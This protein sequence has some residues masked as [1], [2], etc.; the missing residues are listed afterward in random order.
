MSLYSV[1]LSKL[2][3]G[4]ILREYSFFVGF[5]IIFIEKPKVPSPIFT[6]KIKRFSI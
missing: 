3:L 4:K 1:V 5:S 6:S 2:S